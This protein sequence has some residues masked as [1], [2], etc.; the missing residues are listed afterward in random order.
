MPLSEEHKR[1][2]RL[3]K[4][5]KKH[6]HKTSNGGGWKLSD[7]TKKKMSLAQMGK[8]HPHTEETRIKMSEHHKG[9]KYK[10]MSEIG[11]LNIGKAGLGRKQSPEQIEKRM[12]KLR[13]KDSPHWK[14][15][16]TPIN[17]KIRK[18]L[19]YKLWR[20]SVF[21]R[22]NYTCIWCGKRGG[23]LHADH[24]KPF[25]SY[26]ELRFAIDN[27]RALCE[28]CHKATETYGGNT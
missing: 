4:L 2:L 6:N 24:I 13:G 20:K 9:K 12:S 11:R 23:R 18:S 22:D 28:E 27:G 25:A 14:G 16:I 15:G 3:V 8:G 5:G 19:E 21:E 17:E 7:E 1:K 10:P 26:P